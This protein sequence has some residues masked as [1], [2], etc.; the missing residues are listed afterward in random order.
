MEWGLPLK[1]EWYEMRTPES[2]WQE[3]CEQ[4]DPFKAELLAT[5]S[6]ELRSPLA[7]IKGYTATL[8]RY[9]RRL[10]R[11]E[12]HQFLLAINEGAA[13][14]ERIVESLFEISQLE[15][16][17]ITL[18]RSLI[19]VPLLAQ[20]ALRAVEDG[21]PAQPDRQFTFRLLLEDSDGKPT[22]NVPFHNAD[23]ARLRESLAIL[24]DNAVKYSPEGG[25]I[26]VIIRPAAVAGPSAFGISDQ[27]AG[28]NNNHASASESHPMLE[29]CVTD[30]GIG[31][32]PEHIERIFERFYRIDLCLT[33]EVDGLGLGLAIC[34]HII[35]LHNG[36][37]WAESLPE[38]GSAFHVLLPLE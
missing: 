6:H 33:R 20:K 28:N 25:T 14:M 1:E 10:P 29:I 21:L 5:V 31:I 35:E 24:L 32:A 30:T 15:T 9:E 12:R 26:T 36:T 38:K 16:G 18:Q 13:R 34:R 4:A 8:L 7:A 22:R 19:D 37:I 17:A 11:E 2:T 3:S 23:P 27:Q